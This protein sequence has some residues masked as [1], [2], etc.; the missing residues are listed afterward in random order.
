MRLCPCARTCCMHVCV[1]PT[2]DSRVCLTRPEVEAK[3]ERDREEDLPIR[4]YGSSNKV[5]TCM[6]TAGTIVS[7]DECSSTSRNMFA[8]SHIHTHTHVRMYM[9]SYAEHAYIL[10]LKVKTSLSPWALSKEF[11]PVENRNDSKRKMT[12]LA[13]LRLKIISYKSKSVLICLIEIKKQLHYM[14]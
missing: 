4:S 8:K 7:G 9:Q 11:T 5:I 1:F 14:S 6:Q 10:A 3:N 2:C 13:A 12:R